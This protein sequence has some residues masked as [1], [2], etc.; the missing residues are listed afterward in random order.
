MRK[1]IT[2]LMTCLVGFGSYASANTGQVIFDAGYRHDTINWK[3]KFPSEDPLLSFNN[4]FRD[5][6]IFQLGLHGRTTLGCNF[7]VR[8]DAYWGWILDG[9]FDRKT[10]LFG[11]ISD[12]YGS[13]RL[14]LS[15]KFRNNLE[16]DYVFGVGAAV[17]YPFY[18]CDCQLL[19]APV[20]GYAFDEQNVRVDNLGPTFGED[21]CGYFGLNENGCC[22][23]VF[24]SRWYGPFVG[25]DF[26]YRPFNSCVNVWGELEYHWATFSGRQTNNNEG[27]NNIDPFKRYIYNVSAL[28]LSAGLDYDL[29][30]C[31]TVGVSVK[32]QD[33]SGSR[34]HRLRGDIDSDM[35]FNDNRIRNSVS[36]RSY[37]VNLTLGKE[38]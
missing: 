29:S 12:Y 21:S 37:A 8:G 3:T 10:E 23:H 11:D 22:R 1:W 16:G 24:I 19:L 35:S 31:W 38:F 27:S 13:P 4:K 26:D 25:V 9:R 17:G 32:F 33:W 2:L 18:F 30:N 36:W 7:Y 34:H 15:D 14:G 6:D 20:I 5:L 28:V